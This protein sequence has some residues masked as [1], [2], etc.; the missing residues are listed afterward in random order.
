MSWI[1]IDVGGTFTDAVAYDA[2]RGELRSE[3]APTTPSKPQQGVLDALEKLG[4]KLSSAERLIHGLTLGTNTVLERKGADVWV[5]T[6]SGFRDTLEI[7]RT[8]RPIL[9]NIKTLKAAPL[10]PRSRILEVSQRSLRDGSTLREIDMEELA[11][12]IETL[13][14]AEARA[15]AVC[16]LHSYVNPEPERT[17][18]KAIETALPDCFVTTSADVL[19]EYREYER[20]STA[21]LNAYTGP[22]VSRYLSSL[23]E[24]L[25]ERGYE[26]PVFIMTSN[27]G[28]FTADRASRFPVN[29]I[30]SGPAGGVAAAVALGEAIGER[31]LITYDMGGTSTD[32]CLLKDLQVPVTNEQF[33]SDF[34]N[35]TPQ[36]EINTVGAGGGSIAWLDAGPI[37]R[38][39]PQSAGAQPG[40]ASY[41]RGGTEPTVT[42]A[43]VVMARIDP[44]G[45]LAGSVRMRPDL[46]E[47][48]IDAVVSRM[49]DLTRHSLAEGIVRI[50]V[51]RMVSAIKEISIGMG[52]DPREFALLAYGGAGPLH[53]VAIAEELEI[54]K[55]IVPPNPGNFSA[56]GA[57]LSDVRHDYVRTHPMAFAD[58]NIA[59]M[60]RI[61]AEMEAEGA[62]GLEAEAIEAG[63]V[64]M[65]RFCGMRYVGQSWELS[66]ELPAGPIDLAAYAKAFHTLHEQRYG[67]SAENDPL[68]IVNFRLAVIGLMSKPSLPEWTLG[69]SFEQAETSRRDVLFDGEFVATPVYDRAKLPVGATFSGPAIVE[70][71]GSVTVIPKQWNGSVD[72]LGVMILTKE[73]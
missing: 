41:D 43:N 9:Y 31:N 58:E 71:S 33:I 11:S 39:G 20:Y 63:K 8:N 34:P 3:K 37:L 61:F 6:N 46:A 32:V 69:G 16:L 70:E 52:H 18:A 7:A 17:I 56:Y 29:T 14:K 27:G 62:A 10:V 28:V 48:A 22:R 38:V 24:A 67:H 49:A 66:V 51:A 25:D 44:N 47:A 40:P 1:G 65:R 57:I 53:A 45:L 72:R 60:E 12:V 64:E 73:Q 23:D 21:V 5:V 68:E 55:V 19:P 4:I 2:V 30:L 35:R 15:V 54:P 36:I 42:D 13:R 59:E 26:K 50:A